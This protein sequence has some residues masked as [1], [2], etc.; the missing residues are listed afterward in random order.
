MTTGALCTLSGTLAG[1]LA[2]RFAIVEA[3]KV[4]ADDP[5]AYQELTRGAPSE[6]R[7]TPARQTRHV[8]QTPAF[9]E[10]VVAPE[11]TG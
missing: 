4:S 3:G 11:V 10:H 6:A 9:T 8:P 7:P 2:E 5:L 1:T